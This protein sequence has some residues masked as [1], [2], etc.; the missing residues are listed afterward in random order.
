MSILVLSIGIGLFISLIFSE[1]FGLVAGGMI[2]PGYFALYLHQPIPIAFTL[3]IAYFAYLVA[4]LM[5]RFFIFYGKRRTVF[6]ILL[7][8]LLGILVDQSVEVFQDAQPIGFI[9]PGLI[10]IWM[11]RQ[12]ILETLSTLI[13][14]STAVRLVL[15]LWIGEELHIL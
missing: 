3:A 14:V 10:A 6:L 1:L 12:G 15:I 11:D 9:I 7:S 13:I 8:F 2:V 4:K 5:S